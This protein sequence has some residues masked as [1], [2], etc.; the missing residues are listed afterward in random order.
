MQYGSIQCI[1]LV[2]DHGAENIPASI[3]SS[4]YEKNLKS[5]AIP[6]FSYLHF[7]FHKQN[8]K[9][10]MNLHNLLDLVKDFITST[11]YLFI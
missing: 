4:L 10:N 7:D 1:N 5:M 3:Y 8:S 6:T 2:H 9:N 11:Q